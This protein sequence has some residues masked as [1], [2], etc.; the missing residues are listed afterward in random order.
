MNACRSPF[1]AATL[2]G[3]RVYAIRIEANVAKLPGLL[4]KPWVADRLVVSRD[5]GGQ[6]GQV[7]KT[8]ASIF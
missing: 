8:L 5:S 2:R 1:P 6:N 4:R 7:L 3:R